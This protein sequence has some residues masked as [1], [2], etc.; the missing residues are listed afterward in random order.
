MGRTLNIVIEKTENNYAAY[1]PSLLGCIATG[2][3]LEDVKKNMKVAIKMHLKGMD[4]DN[5]K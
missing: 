5:K 3:T 1:C 2:K 4:E